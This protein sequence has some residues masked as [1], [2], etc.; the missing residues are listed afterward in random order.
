MS[1]RNRCM[2]H[3][4]CGIRGKRDRCGAMRGDRQILRTGRGSQSNGGGKRHMNVGGQELNL[5]GELVLDVIIG[6]E[7]FCL[8]I[9]FFLFFFFYFFSS[10]FI[11][12]MRD[13]VFFSSGGDPSGSGQGRPGLESW[14]PSVRTKVRVLISHKSA[15]P[16]TPVG[17][18]G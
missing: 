17:R 11:L 9:L 1:V 7:V 2:R 4:S 5:V 6:D 12:F 3:R 15:F 16:D 14:E 13:I 10:R 18:S 8:E